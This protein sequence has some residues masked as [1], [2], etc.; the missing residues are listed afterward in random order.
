MSATAVRIEANRINAQSSTG[1][2]TEEG[3]TRASLNALRHGITAK[4]P[5]LPGESRD[6]YEK[7]QHKFVAGLAPSGEVETRLARNMADLQWRIRRCQSLHLDVLKATVTEPLQQVDALNKLALYEQRLTR[8]FLANMKEFRTLQT[9]RSQREVIDIQDAANRLKL[10]QSK[11]LPYDP[12]EDGFVFSKQ[13]VEDFVRRR[14]R[15]TEAAK[16]S[17]S[18]QPLPATA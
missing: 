13:Q 17:E 16:A 7:F 2:R 8:T 11:Q 1:P 5:V 18:Q 10:C 6:P 12:A 14:D 9:E 3:K 4:S 15:L